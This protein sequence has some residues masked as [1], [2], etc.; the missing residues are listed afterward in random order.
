MNV[1]L[2]INGLSLSSRLSTYSVTKEINYRKVIT[3]LDGVERP[4]PGIG[5]PVI[6]FSLIP[7]TEDEDTALYDALK[8]LICTVT[9]SDKGVDM[10]K[11]MR[12]VS[13]LESSF[14]L[15]SADGKRRY[16][17]AEIQLRGL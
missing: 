3:T 6:I 12:I 15:T 8:D 4:Y 14:L 2:T 13:N 16:K 7:G 5:K 11:D 10:T 9:Y 17:Q 1:T